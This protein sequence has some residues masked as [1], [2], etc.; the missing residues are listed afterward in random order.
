MAVKFQYRPDCASSRCINSVCAVTR[1]WPNMF[2]VICSCEMGFVHSVWPSF[3]CK[4]SQVTKKM[5]ATA[6]CHLRG[7]VYY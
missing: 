2:E 1:K 5:E 3:V 4:R 6:L 7:F